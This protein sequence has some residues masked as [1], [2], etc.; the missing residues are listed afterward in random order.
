MGKS[1]GTGVVHLHISFTASYII[2]KLALKEELAV[3]CYVLYTPLC[4]WET[5]EQ[6]CY[7]EVVQ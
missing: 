3:Q 1:K 5:M 4:T 7:S 6:A 2:I